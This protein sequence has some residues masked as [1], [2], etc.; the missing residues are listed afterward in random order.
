M[1][2]III[3]GNPK[4]IKTAVA[5]QYYQNIEKF[6]YDIGVKRVSFDSGADYT[7]PPK[8]DVYI[9]HSRGV[10]RV[11]LCKNLGDHN[12]LKFGSLDGIIHPVD[13]E[14]QKVTAPGTGTPPKEHFL[15]T[16]EQQ[17]AI[18]DMYERV[19]KIQPKSSGW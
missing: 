11:D 18:R 1:Y 14:W 4:F 16:E 15:F 7:C 3:K 2:V 9:A 19:R 10:A 13:A 6:L 17:Q 8:A 12:S 5:R